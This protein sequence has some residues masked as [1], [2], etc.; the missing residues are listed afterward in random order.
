MAAGHHRARSGWLFAGA[1]LLAGIP[2][3]PS[4]ADDGDAT[5]L[6]EVVTVTATS[7]PLAAFDYPGMVS[8]IDSEQIRLLQ[9]STTDDLLK[10]VPNVEVTGGPRRTGMQPSIRGFTGPDVVVTVDG[11]RQNFDSAH[12]GRYFLDPSLLRSVE[13]VRGPS[14]SLYGSGGTGGVIAFRTIRAE[15]LLRADERA[16]VRLSGGYQSVND[17]RLAVVTAYGRPLRQLDLVG[18][19]TRRESG[20][21]DLG[22]GSTLDRTDDALDAAL[23]K[24][25]WA[26]RPGQR[27]ELTWQGFSGDAQE[28][29]NGQGVGG[30]DVVDKRIRSSDL[31]LHYSWD[32]GTPWV[33]LTAV[34]YRN[35]STV[36]ELALD[37]LGNVPAG[38]LQRRT[39]ATRGARIDNRS[40]FAIGDRMDA[41]LTYG[42]ELWQDDQQGSA[43]AAERGGVPDARA[44]FRAAFVQAELSLSR[45][46]GLPGEVFLL[47]GLR[48]DDFEG[49]DDA[50]RETQDAAESR[51]LG[52]SWRPNAWGL[53]F[54]NWGEAFRA[55]RIGEL[56]QNGVH[57]RIPL[58]PGVVNRFVPNTA[59]AP[60][61]TATFEYGAGVDL[62]ALLADGDRLQLKGS[63]FR[64][65]AEELIDLEVTQ[66]APFAACDPFVFGACDGTTR[67]INVDDAVLEGWELEA[68][69][70][71]PRTRIA[72]GLSDVDGRN[73]ITG[74]DLGL[75]TPVQ[76]TLDAAL[77]FPGQGATAGWRL[78][79][80]AAFDEVAEPELERDGYL[81][82]DFYLSWQPEAARSAYR[83]D[84]QLN[85]AFDENYARVFTGAPQPGR[86]LAVRLTWTP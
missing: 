71:H 54:A 68:T 28:P 44:R 39:I 23:L 10:W 27:L 13:V 42:A 22:D 82:H 32:S 85:N 66:P 18:S 11:T 56:F 21:I 86:N 35:E 52:V 17:E 3:P 78:M 65:D 8:V 38:T 33:D 7:N 49:Q 59:L 75:L 20:E 12:D 63:R 77:R 15:D 34:A 19:V 47:P 70:T 84:L 2:A 60:Q 67:A 55:P 64:T 53:L 72:V 51:R 9:P 31:R 61:R 24:A 83:V 62:V 46:L 80:A 45:P 48:R 4:A 6:L 30:D 40:R 74:D 79:A 41:T 14:S 73:R 76:L 37:A 58:G 16:G 25:G 57:F 26:L 36:D 29:N 1:A 50:G 5:P 81:V 69:Y 43:G